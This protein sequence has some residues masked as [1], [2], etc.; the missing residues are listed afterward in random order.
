MFL[1]LWVSV[2]SA[3]SC[4]WRCVCICECF[5]V[6]NDTDAPSSSVS[7]A[8]AWMELMDAL[9]L[10]VNRALIL[11]NNFSRWYVLKFRSCCVCRGGLWTRYVLTAAA[12]AATFNRSIV[13]FIS[14]RSHCH[15][16]PESV[17]IFKNCDFHSHNFCSEYTWPKIRI[18]SELKCFNKSV[19]NSNNWKTHA[20]LL[21]ERRGKPDVNTFV[22]LGYYI[23]TCNCSYLGSFRAFFSEC[24][25]NVR[26]KWFVFCAY[27]AFISLKYFI[28]IG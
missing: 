18:H 3:L 22:L 25:I 19:S 21:V 15:G 12:A 17:R 26:V 6:E 5:L 16:E 11:C 27:I 23:H 20:K 8:A 2:I 10:I 7:C 13:L 9:L 14:Q 28:L 1:W 24:F 4:V